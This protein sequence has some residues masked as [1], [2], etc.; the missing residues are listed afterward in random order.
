M[1]SIAVLIG[2]DWFAGALRTVMNV[3]VDVLVGMLVS[4][5]LGEFDAD[6]YNEKI[7]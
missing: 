6:V 2:I 1:E 7:R 5:D 3:N 4:K